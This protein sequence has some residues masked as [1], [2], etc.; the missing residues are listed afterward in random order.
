MRQPAHWMP[1]PNNGF[2]IPQPS[3]GWCLTFRQV[4]DAV[5]A[6]LES[7]DTTCLIV[8]HRL[9]TIARAERIL[10]LEGVLFESAQRSCPKSS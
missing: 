4:N 3:T 6:I 8:A 2:V 5:D 9:S 10:V 7:R 1:L